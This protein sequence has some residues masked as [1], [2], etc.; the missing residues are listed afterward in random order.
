MP[1]GLRE[2]F[3]GL[4]RRHGAQAAA[5]AHTIVG[6]A[7]AAEDLVQDAFL[8][9][10]ENAGRYDLTAR[11]P[12]PLIFKILTRRALNYRRDRDALHERPVEDAVHMNETSRSG[13]GAGS[14]RGGKPRSTTD[15]KAGSDERDALLESALARLPGK[16]RMALHLR[17]HEELTYR[18][19]GEILGETTDHVG[20]LIYRS[21]KALRR[22]L[23]PHLSC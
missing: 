20:I 6:D 21:K 9:L 23:K 2:L 18:Q 22:M 13:H 7:H 17:V 11:D 16:Q 14:V 8:A 19:I 3:D 10:Y 1:H 4:L 12:R 15:E 5:Y